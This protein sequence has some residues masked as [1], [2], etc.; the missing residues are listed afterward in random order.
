[1]EVK[2]MKA[3]EEDLRLLMESMEDHMLHDRQDSTRVLNVLIEET[4]KFRDKLKEDTGE[5]LTVADAQ[6]ALNALD[7]HFNNQ[8]IPENLTAEQKALLQIWIDR[9]TIFDNNP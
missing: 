1:V 5:V 7:C 6:N 2:S 3:S 8:S 9:L 4:I